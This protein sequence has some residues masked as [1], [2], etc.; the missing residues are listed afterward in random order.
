MGFLSFGT[1]NANR[2]N[3]T[4]SKANTTKRTLREVRFLA[5]LV[6]RDLVVGVLAALAVAERFARLRHV[7]H[8]Y[9]KLCNQKTLQ[10]EFASTAVPKRHASGNKT[11][12]NRHET[13]EN[14]IE[15]HQIRRKQR[16]ATR[17]KSEIMRRKSAREAAHEFPQCG[18]LY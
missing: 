8:L 9:L 14:I 18:L 5:L 17:Q 2:T 16:E 1:T 4:R 12:G 10:N 11:L 13:L 3:S 15:K 6:L 7:H